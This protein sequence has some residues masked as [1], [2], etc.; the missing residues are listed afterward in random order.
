M[1]ACS[2]SVV[3]LY[4]TV[5]YC[6]VGEIANPSPKAWLA[7]LDEV[8]DMCDAHLM[9]VF[10]LCAA[11]LSAVLDRVAWHG[12]M[13]ALEAVSTLK[14]SPALQNTACTVIFEGILT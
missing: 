2:C 5:L 9:D 12:G 6:L 10:L 7:P 4:S 14:S 8:S 1:S 13:G 11:M 3:V